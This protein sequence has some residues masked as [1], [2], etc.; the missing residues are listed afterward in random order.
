MPPTSEAIHGIPIPIASISAFGELSCSDGKTKT[1]AVNNTEK[2]SSQKPG[3]ITCSESPYSAVSARSSASSSPSP[4][5]VH[6][7]ATS[8]RSNKFNASIR[9]RCPFSGT[10]RPTLTINFSSEP[11]AR[12]CVH[13]SVGN[14]NRLGML[15]I[16]LSGYRWWRCRWICAEFVRRTSA[17]L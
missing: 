3:N 9:Y 14:S 6:R 17:A 11:P 1:S 15:K 16:C 13:V 7:H 10:N 5:N 4:R 2:T 12:G 8:S